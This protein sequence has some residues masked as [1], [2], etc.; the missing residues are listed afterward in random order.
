MLIGHILHPGTFSVSGGT[1]ADNL[2]L[3]LFPQS[4]SKTLTNL[5]MYNAP[6]TMFRRYASVCTDCVI[7]PAF[8]A[9]QLHFK[10][11]AF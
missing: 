4:F 11:L 2:K 1:L 10:V 3:D 7:K 9:Q 6:A 8:A 5:H